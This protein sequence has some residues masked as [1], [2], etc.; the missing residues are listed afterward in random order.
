MD[1]NAIDWRQAWSQYQYSRRASDNAEYWNGRAKSF[2]EHAGTS[3]YA[4]EF[5]KLAAL[6]D[7]E[8]VLDMGC[9]SGT[10]AIP[11]AKAGH[12]VWA[13]DFS[14][15]MLEILERVAAEQGVGDM[16]HTKLLSWA[17]D[18]DAAGVPVCDVSLASRSMAA[19][20][21]WAAIEKLDSRGRRRT[22]V[23]MG[24]HLSPRMDPVI[25][26]ALGRPDPGLAEFVYAMNM[27]WVMGKHPELTNI[28]SPRQDYFERAEDAIAKHAEIMEATPTEIELLR[29]Y[30]ADHLVEVETADGPRLRFDHDRQTSWAF[31]SW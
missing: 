2:Y 21:L 25:M 23:T 16:I 15:A 8:T 31:M 9:G 3:P 22:C 18:W 6:H 7:G 5:I 1:I 29:A 4:A 19:D 27:L 14:S 12:E 26:K 20:D 24:T 30:C 28:T 11:L 10:L 17:D 13:C